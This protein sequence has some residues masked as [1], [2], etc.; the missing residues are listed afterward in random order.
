MEKG[1]WNKKPYAKNGTEK[2]LSIKLEYGDAFS[3]FQKNQ[4]CIQVRE[5]TK[6]VY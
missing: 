6:P 1:K 3:F 2:N 5:C 4:Q